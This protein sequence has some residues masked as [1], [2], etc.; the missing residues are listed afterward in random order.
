MAFYNNT[1]SQVI[2]VFAYDSTDGSART[3]DA[4]NITAQISL[5]GGTAA[6]T[7]DTNPTELDA[8]DHPGV[9]LFTMTQAETNADLVNL[10]PVSATANILLEPVFVYT[11]PVGIKT[12]GDNYSATRGLAG[13]ALPAAAADGVGGLPI[14]DAGGLDMDAILADTNELQTNQGNWLTA[15]GFATPTNVTSAQS[16]IISQGNTVWATATGFAVAGDKMDFVDAP[17]S[18]AVTAIQDGLATTVELAKV[19]KVGRTTKHR[20]VDTDEE[21]AVILEE[22]S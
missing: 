16:A 1:A 21:A 8:T 7:N 17:N 19:P 2:A 22:V 12:A 13:T 20:N 5:D 18:T 10:T 11:L 3:G 15:T 6:A 4:A 9:Y 14:S